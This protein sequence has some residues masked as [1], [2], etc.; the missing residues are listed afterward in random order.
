MLREIIPFALSITAT[1][2]DYDAYPMNYTTGNALATSVTEARG[3]MTLSGSIPEWISGDL[4]WVGPGKFEF[5]A[6]SYN[7]LVDGQAMVH[8][9]RI[10]N[11]EIDFERKFIQTDTFKENTE[12]GH[13]V[14]SEPAT[15]AEPDDLIDPNDGP[16][17]NGLKRFSYYNDHQ[18]DNTNVKL[19]HFSG[20]MLAFNEQKTINVLDPESLETIEKI[21]LDDYVPEDYQVVM[22]SAHPD[23][24]E[25]GS[26]VSH[27]VCLDFSHKIPIPSFAFFVFKV[28]ETS[29]KIET[30][31]AGINWSDPIK[32][33]NDKIL[34]LIWKKKV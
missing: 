33:G 22:Q 21:N 15:Y 14:V 2:V 23:V 1:S 5:G 17:K 26:L 18:T 27:V 31:F 24:D 12:A 19:V 28:P 32:V 20:K 13:I 4:Y 30:A 25:N 8:R 16:M 3:K 9:F 34:T 6:D 10:K 7:S 29:G 11:G